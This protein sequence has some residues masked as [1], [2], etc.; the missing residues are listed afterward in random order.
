[1]KTFV[2][3]MQSS[4][5]SLFTYFLCQ[6]PDTIGIIDLW[7]GNGFVA[8]PFEDIDKD[9]ILKCTVN[10]RVPLERH[11]ASFEPDLTILFLRERGSN[12]ESLGKKR[13]RD[14]GGRMNE[15]FAQLER[16]VQRR[17]LF[18]LV[19]TYEDFVSSP[20]AILS[21]LGDAASPSYYEFKRT[22]REMLAFA[23]THSSWCR[24]FY[25][26]Q[27]GFGNIHFENDGS[28]I[29]SPTPRKR[30]TSLVHL[31]RETREYV[32]DYLDDLR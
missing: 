17:D 13:Y 8:P 12:G 28:V 9:V 14:A 10:S 16:D 5:A 23:R 4:G 1:M 15:K 22:R 32:W 30:P 29:L 11:L 7:S 25:R 31:Y 3:G 19:L 20:D 26:K 2:Y 21:A 6:R 18:D 27:W 24:E